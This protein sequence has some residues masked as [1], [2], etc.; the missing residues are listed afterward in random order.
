MP[1]LCSPSRSHPQV[2]TQLVPS[3]LPRVRR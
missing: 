2:R 1:C 3:M